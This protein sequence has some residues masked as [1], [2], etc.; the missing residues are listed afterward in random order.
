[1]GIAFDLAN[2]NP[3]VGDVADQTLLVLSGSGS[4]GSAS[5][6]V[7]AGT[8]SSIT[9]ATTG[10]SGSSS[11]AILPSSLWYQVV[12]GAV[13]LLCLAVLALGSRRAPTIDKLP[14]AS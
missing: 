10:T 2:G 9:S 3:Y 13:I 5:T 11:L 7:T 1:M 14:R 4:T 6:S 12:A 8:A